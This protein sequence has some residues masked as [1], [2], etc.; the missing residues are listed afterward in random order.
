VNF[1]FRKIEDVKTMD[2]RNVPT[3]LLEFITP[4]GSLGTWVASAWTTDP[5]LIEA[6]RNGYAQMGAAMAPGY[7]RQ[8]RRPAKPPPWTASDSPFSSVPARVMHPFSLTLLKATHT[9]YPGADIPKDFRSR[10]RI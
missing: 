10:V 8:A 6:V 4:A 9:V 3:A 1:D 2:A 7:C 5:A